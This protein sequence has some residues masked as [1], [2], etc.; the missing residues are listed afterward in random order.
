MGL[1]LA[2]LAAG[3]DSSEELEN[4]EVVERVLGLGF[5]ERGRGCGA[6]AC[7]GVCASVDQ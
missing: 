4:E 5:L 3:L 7:V 6:V 2:S 1:G